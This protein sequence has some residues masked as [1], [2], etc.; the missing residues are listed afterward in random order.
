MRVGR[1]LHQASL[2]LR[3][4][5]AE[6]RALCPQGSDPTQWRGVEAASC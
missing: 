6:P 1:A 4:A 5:E 3:W 2:D